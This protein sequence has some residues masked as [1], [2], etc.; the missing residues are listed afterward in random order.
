MF[1]FLF[2]LVVF[3]IFD[4]IFIQLVKDSLSREAAAILVDALKNR[5]R[6]F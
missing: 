3:K 1:E 2:I 4:V 6:I 5:K